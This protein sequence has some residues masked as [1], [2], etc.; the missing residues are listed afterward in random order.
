MLWYKYF[1]M[2]FP[3]DSDFFF[4][5]LRSG[6]NSKTMPELRFTTN[7]SLMGHVSQTYHFRGH[8]TV[9]VLETVF[10]NELK[11]FVL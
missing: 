2:Y 4:M 6:P 3:F 1:S 9:L 8:I 11:L 5:H 10:M 7:L